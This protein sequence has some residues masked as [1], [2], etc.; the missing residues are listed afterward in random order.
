MPGCRHGVL[1][2]ERG[3]DVVDGHGRARPDLR[4][5]AGDRVEFGE[6]AGDLLGHCPRRH[7]DLGLLAVR[8]VG[9][10][11][12]R[13]A[14]HVRQVGGIRAG[15]LRARG[16]R[17]SGP[18]DG[19][20]LGRVPPSDLGLLD[21]LGRGDRG[22]HAQQVSAQLEDQRMPGRPAGRGASAAGAGRAELELVVADRDLVTDLP[23]QPAEEVPVAHAT[24]R[25]VVEDG[26][27]RFDGADAQAGPPGDLHRHV[28]RGDLGVGLRVAAAEEPVG[29]VV[30]A[31]QG[32]G[33]GGVEVGL[34]GGDLA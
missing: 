7:V 12:G 22:S 25:H 19:L 2:V 5:A 27:G 29:Q 3:P 9:A 17:R 31:D 33:A 10:D 15:Q 6:R 13:I 21:L 30:A 28:R 32:E 14:E 8:H 1:A 11:V 20:L 16:A 18:D 24:L 26:R 23:G 4:V 34:Q